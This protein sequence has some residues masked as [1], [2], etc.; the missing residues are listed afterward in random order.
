MGPQALV[1]AGVWLP[2][3]ELVSLLIPGSIA[4]KPR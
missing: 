3:D 4:R 1:P 2:F